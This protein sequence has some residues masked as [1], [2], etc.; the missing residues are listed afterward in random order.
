M[1]QEKKRLFAGP[2]QHSFHHHS[3][4]S[5]TSTYTHG[6]KLGKALEKL[7]NRISCFLSY[8]KHSTFT[9]NGVGF[10]LLH[11]TNLNCGKQNKL[12][13]LN[14]VIL[15]GLTTF[16]LFFLFFFFCMENKGLGY[17]PL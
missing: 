11:S 2:D 6:K 12:G 4:N 9:E 16:M 7:K 14:L 15:N 1:G 13:I 10:M 5:I 17:F 3:R 8:M